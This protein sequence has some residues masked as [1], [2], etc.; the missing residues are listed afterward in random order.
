MYSEQLLLPP[1]R[2][3]LASYLSSSDLDYH[4]WTMAR[5]CPI[6]MKFWEKVNLC[7]IIK[8]AKFGSIR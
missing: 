6:N 1:A 5:S 8:F 3:D 7:N 2:Q 4:F